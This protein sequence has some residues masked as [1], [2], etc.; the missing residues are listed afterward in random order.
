[1]PELTVEK[2]SVRFGGV[3]A[4]DGVDLS[5]RTGTVTGLI[6]PNGAGKTTLFNVITGLQSP[7]R[8]AVH[9]DDQDITKMRPHR[10]ARLGISRTF[11]RLEM[12]GA[13]SARENVQLAAEAQAS[14][15]PEGL[16]LHQWVAQLLERVG[17]ASVADEPADTL[18]TGLARLVEVAR[19]LATRPAF[20]LL[21]EPSSGL[22]RAETEALGRVLL[23]LAAEGVGVLL[24]EHDMG[25]V[26]STCEHVVVLDYG[27][28]IA[29]GDPG[30][31]KNDPA[32]Q[33][34]YLGT[35]EP[36][37]DG[38]RPGPPVAAPAREAAWGREAPP[39]LE[40]KDVRA[41]YG[42][43][44]VLHGVSLAVRDGAVC[45]LLGPNGAGKST[46]LKVISGRLPVTGGSVSIAGE[47]LVRPRPARLARQGICAIPEGRA[48]FPN[49]TV[50]E[51]LLMCTYR[52]DGLSADVIEQKTF[53]RF[54][55]LGQRR[56]QLAG[57]LSGGEQQM[58]ALARAMF[59]HPRLLLLD[60]I[61]MGLAPTLVDSLYDT[62][63]QLVADE[64]LTVLVVEQ[65]A[66]KALALAT[67][68]AVLIHG[69][70]AKT[71]TPEE[72]GD[73]VSSAYLT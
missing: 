12:V 44:E 35:A 63:G 33:Q 27:E 20:V 49:L 53:E 23:S 38:T 40:L 56:K 15:V 4:L 51:N 1:L 6:G 5:V 54:P 7:T 48:V 32:V 52:G 50:T 14:R 13:L 46:L 45:A 70:I 69:E 30:T 61:S 17:V 47:P 21:D 25:L 26:M 65:F 42:R 72:I 55:R 31:I 18:P 41:A 59:T 71:G 73:Y 37:D 28:V 68:A 43:I 34:A 58:L 60:E 8:G 19:A 9:L 67:D 16:T 62:V 3:Q 64:H 11:Q 24:V 10:R 2:V 29:G 57:T 36:V 66:H 39:A 22:D